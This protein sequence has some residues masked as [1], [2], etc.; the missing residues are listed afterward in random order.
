[1]TE[2]TLYV[3]G[4]PVDGSLV[5][6]PITITHGRS[7]TYAQ[8]DAPSIDFETWGPTPVCQVGDLIEF[9]AARPDAVWRDP[10][11]Q[12]GDPEVTWAGATPETTI[13]PPGAL[14]QTAVR[15]TGTVSSVTAVEAVGDVESW[16]VRAVG[17]LARLGRIKVSLDRPDE[18]DSARVAAIAQDA[19]VVITIL[20]NPSLTLAADSIDRDALAAI[21][22][23]C[24]STGGLFWQARNGDL[25]YGTANH[26][27]GQVSDTLPA[28]TI[29]DGIDWTQDTAQIV[30]HVTIT[31]PSQPAQ[32]SPNAHA[33]ETEQETYSDPDS[34]AAWGQRHAEANTLCADAD[35]AGLLALTILA[36][37][38]DPYWN[39]PGVLIPMMDLNPVPLKVVAGLEVSDGVLVPVDTNPTPT[40][41]PV[42][43]WAVEGWAEQ[44]TEDGERWMQLALSD[45]ARSSSAILRDYGEVRDNFTY[46]TAVLKT[47]Q[48]LIAEVV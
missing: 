13:P 20:G 40:P 48:R 11:A 30:N 1:V 18:T 42:N 3:N 25:F 36:R 21:H 17:P 22:E 28:Q 41:A 31:W 8:P 19:G 23:V 27:S 35:E 45:W 6:L 12:W 43:Q 39:M 9:T 47:Y 7:S 24:E 38:A 44:W 33:G 10:A 37:R 29:L 46:G 14:A 16:S 32:Q 5:F 26:R 2:G 34:I 4:T 15:F